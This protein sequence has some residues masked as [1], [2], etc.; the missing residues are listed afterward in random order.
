MHKRFIATR[1]VGD[2]Q[3]YGTEW[4]VMDCETDDDPYIG[5]CRSKIDAEDTASRYNAHP[6]LAPTTPSVDYSGSWN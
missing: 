5:P 6:M 3:K 1:I 2:D 4:F